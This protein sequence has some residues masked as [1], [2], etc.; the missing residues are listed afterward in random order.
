ML[1]SVP[2]VSFRITGVNGGFTEVSGLLTLEDKALKIEVES[3]DAIVGILRSDVKEFTLGFDRI[4]KVS[5]SSGFLRSAKFLIQTV[6]MSDLTAIPGAKLGQLTLH[7][8]RNDRAD[9]E[10]LNSAFQLS[11]SEYRLNQLDE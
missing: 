9:A 7:I 4:R 1:S 8:R 10:A 5:Y 6:S 2:S 11:F 3:A